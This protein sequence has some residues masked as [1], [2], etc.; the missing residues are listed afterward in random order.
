M[1]LD[2]IT[3]NMDMIIQNEISEILS[4]KPQDQQYLNYLD[5]RQVCS[6]VKR[7]CIDSIGEIPQEVEMAC[8]LAEAVLAPDKKDKKQLIKQAVSLASGAGGVAC[9]LA[10]VGSA[11]GWGTGVLA[12]ITAFFVGTS[13]TI[14]LIA[15]TGGLVLSVVAGYFMFHNNAPTLSNK[16]IKALS[17]GV[18]KALAAYWERRS[19]KFTE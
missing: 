14:P 10:G 1:T 9:I 17:K 7:Y 3:V 5:M 8:C 2:Q 19:I 11:L 15:I 12:A 6:T 16:A 18:E 13:V 4:T